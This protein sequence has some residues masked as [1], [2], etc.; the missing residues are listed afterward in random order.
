MQTDHAGVTTAQT[1]AFTATGITLTQTDGRGNAT[2]TKTD[3]AGRT[4]SVTDAAGNTTTTAYSPCCDN[5]ATVTDALGNTV[6]SKY[7][8]RGRKIAEWGTA[9]QPAL[10]AYDAADRMTSLTTFRADAGDITTDPS[11]RTDGDTTNWE[12]HDATGL[13]LKKPT[14]TAPMRTPPTTP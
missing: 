10:F 9:I 12:Y 6:H 8:A 1:R 7:D 14:P 5:P 11:E 13:L 3:I 4:I 2:T